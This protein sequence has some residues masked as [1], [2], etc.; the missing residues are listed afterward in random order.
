MIRAMAHA[1]CRIYFLLTGYMPGKTKPDI[2]QNGIG[3]G[4]VVLVLLSPWL[5]WF[6]MAYWRG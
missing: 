6:A 2:E 5:I 1:Y 4:L 3:V